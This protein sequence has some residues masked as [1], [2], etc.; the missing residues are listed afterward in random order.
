MLDYDNIKSS[1][2]I[3]VP[4][5][6]IDQV[7]GHE[8]SI[9]TIKKAAKQRRNVLLI[10]DPGVGKSMLAKGM[11]QILPHET[12]QD[13]LIYPNVEDNNHPIIRTVPAGEGKKIVRATKGSARGQEERKTLLTTLA[14]GGILVI[15]FF[16]G[17]ILESIIAAALILLISIQI[18][19]K[20]NTMAPKLLVNNEENRFAPFM[21]ATGAHAGALLGDVRHDPYQSGGL[22]TPA[23]ERVEAGMIHKANRGVL[24]IDEIGTM[25]MKT[26]QELLSAMQE[27][28]YAITGQSENS[29]GAMVRSQAVPCD[30]VLVASGNIQ[31]LEGMHIAMRSRIRGY[32]YEVFMK[33][34]MDDT[35]E[36]REKLVQFVAQEVKNDGRIPHFAPDALDEIIMEAKRRSGKQN[37]LTLR[38]RELGGLVRSSGDV[39]I[40]KGEELVKAEHVLEAKKFSRTLE[41]QI[42]DRSITQ[43]KEYSMVNAEGGRV[44][45]VNGLA[46]I[47]DRSGIVS[48]IAAEAAP[49]QS[50]NGGQIIAT[51]KLGEIASESVQNVSALIKKYTNKNLSDY[52]I[53]V[54]FIQTYD[55]VEGDSASVSIATAVISAV[56]DIPIDQ[57]VALTGSLN[58]R[59]D[60]MPIGGATAK[61]EAAA[62]AGMKKVLIPKSNLKD[63]MIEKKYEEMVEI[64]P[65]ETLSD[66]LENILI[67]GSKKDQLIEKMKSIGS[68][69]ADKVPQSPLNN[70]TTH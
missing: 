13:V 44:G 3:E 36:N 27:K 37:A 54:Q 10:G 42:A 6:L 62:E 49:A 25:S 26:Q 20:N 22:G 57:T 63:V 65:T 15:G 69:V 46:V 43:R 11:A 40:E 67:S 1:K 47:G 58:V 51:G 31:V 38:L 45:L 7:I 33:D 61:I 14:I 68:K 35:T 24:Y 55:G 32:G 5:L 59:G 48:P 21:D 18:K 8:E 17:R 19:P 28:Q 39:A 9:E 12:L 4:P 16:Y 29:S 66:V 52:D 30:F 50:K 53:H 56:E 2:D 23:H 41:Q 64:I 70:P 34:Y 60:V